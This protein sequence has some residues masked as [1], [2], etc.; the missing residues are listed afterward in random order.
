MARPQHLELLFQFFLHPH[1]SSMSSHFAVFSGFPVF[2]ASN[3][4]AFIS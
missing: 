4:M 1:I 2:R 3:A